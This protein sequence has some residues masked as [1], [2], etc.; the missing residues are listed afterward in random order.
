MDITTEPR[1]MKTPATMLRVKAATG[2][3][4]TLILFNLFMTR[5]LFES[6]V[7][8]G[9]LPIEH[10]TNPLWDFRLNDVRLQDMF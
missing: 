1:K 9:E 2:F 4:G 7:H 3:V 6:V 8:R 5:T 10:V